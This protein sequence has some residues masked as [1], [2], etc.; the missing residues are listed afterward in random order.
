MC[1]SSSASALPAV[2]HATMTR[3]SPRLSIVGMWTYDLPDPTSATHSFRGSPV[4]R[5]RPPAPHAAAPSAGCGVGS[6]TPAAA[7]PA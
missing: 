6:A 2:C 3:P 1:W 5:T 4:I 7:P